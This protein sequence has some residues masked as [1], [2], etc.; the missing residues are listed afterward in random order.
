MKQPPPLNLPAQ[1]SIAALGVLGLLGGSL[2]VAYAGF[3]TSPRRGG[4]PTF[5]P[6]P[7]AYVMAAIM[8]LMSCIAV[9]VL[10]R[11]HQ[12]SKLAI[13]VAFGVYVAAAAA[14]VGVLARL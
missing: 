4:T 3:Q 7:E 6:A 11:H 12:F 9:L 14:L 13:A 1:I 8:Y 5:V 2:I 10:L